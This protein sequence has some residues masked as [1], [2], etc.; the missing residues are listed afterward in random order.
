MSDREL[1]DIADQALEQK[2]Y[3][4]F[5]TFQLSP[6]RKQ[7]DLQRLA[8]RSFREA[9]NPSSHRKAISI[10]AASLMVVSILVVALAIR[11]Y[12]FSGG[13]VTGVEA[14]ERLFDDPS[15]GQGQ[16]VVIETEVFSVAGETPRKWETEIWERRFDNG[17]LQRAI[18]GRDASG[19][20]VAQLFQTGDQWLY[21]SGGSTQSGEGPLIAVPVETQR[22]LL[23]LS[24]ART[25][26]AS[27]DPGNV[28]QHSDGSI[29]SY[30]LDFTKDLEPEDRADIEDALHIRVE[31]IT[32]VLRID[33]DDQRVYEWATFVVDQR[34][35]THLM[36][37]LR[38]VTWDTMKA[39]E[40]ADNHFV[41]PD[42]PAMATFSIPDDTPLP[43]GL[44]LNSTT[45]TGGG[46]ERI[47]L[48]GN[49]SLVVQLDISESSNRDLALSRNHSRISETGVGSIVWQAHPDYGWPQIALWDDGHFRFQLSILNGGPDGWSLNDL[50]ML[51]EALSTRTVQ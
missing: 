46:R 35:E 24:E 34:G 22:V 27:I 42:L 10:V 8:T 25:L 11:D 17:L 51:A 19:Q 38:F 7:A 15:A 1:N 2:L 36:Q 21:E 14:A 18:T 45:Q 28:E 48:T 37:R 31:Q 20:T 47:V 26:L 5:E 41:V 30:F 43:R 3:R 49:G 44:R 40:I 13:T 29:Q 32:G 39:A 12:L 33:T 9:S 6:L 16:H 50:V 23:N 4:T